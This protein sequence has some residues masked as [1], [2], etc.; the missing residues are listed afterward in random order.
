MSEKREWPEVVGKV[1][2]TELLHI[3]QLIKL[4]FTIFHLR[5]YAQINCDTFSKCIRVI[6]TEPATF[7]VVKPYKFKLILKIPPV[8]AHDQK[9]TII[10]VIYFR[11]KKK[12]KKLF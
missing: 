11:A 6:T 12:R 7:N 8:D 3:F 4:C 2:L 10:I 5:Q 9:V 1:R